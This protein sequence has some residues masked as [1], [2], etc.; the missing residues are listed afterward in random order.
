MNDLNRLFDA[1][2]A[3][4]I[5]FD[6]VFTRASQLTP[7][8]PHYNIFKEDDDHYNVDLALAGYG[9]DDVD[10]T[11]LPGSLTISSASKKEAKD[12]R[13]VY[14]GIAKRD[15]RFTLPL[16]QHVEVGATDFTNGMLRVQLVRNIP[17]AAKPRKIAIG[18]RNESLLTDQSNVVSLQQKQA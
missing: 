2:W 10:I 14:R 13:Q 17:E 8:F 9:P 16:A 3:T 7:S 1:L 4:T 11:W 15:F 6:P 5:G 18:Y 12:E